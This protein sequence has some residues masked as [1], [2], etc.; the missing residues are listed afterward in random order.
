MTSKEAL[1]IL[2]NRNNKLHIN[3][4]IGS[5]RIADEEI[6]EIATLIDKL[7]KEGFTPLVERDTPKKVKIGTLG[8]FKFPICPNCNN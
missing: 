1:D 3:H 6:K 5:R 7:I 4:L 8:D 2:E